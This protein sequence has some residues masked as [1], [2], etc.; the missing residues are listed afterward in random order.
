MN[1]IWVLC[2]CNSEE[3]AE[4]IGN[5][6]V[7]TRAVACFDV[8]EREV[9]GYFWPPKANKK[10]KVEDGG[11]LVLTT[12]EEK[13]AGVVESIRKIHSDKVPFISYIKLEGLNPDYLDWMKSEI[14]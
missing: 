14:S 3:E 4:K 9:S 5:E 2:N 12:F 8:L 6:L 10:E 11:L 13:Y 1:P 7:D